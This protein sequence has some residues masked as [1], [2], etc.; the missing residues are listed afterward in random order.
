MNLFDGL[1]ASL[2]KNAEVHLAWLIAALMIAV[3]VTGCAKPADA[4]PA[5]P[6][7]YAHGTKVIKVQ[8]INDDWVLCV[9]T[10]GG[11][12]YGQAITCDFNRARANP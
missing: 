12:G 7:V 5:T 8:N 1:P 2:K 11:Y 6:G 10:S 4:A 3:V 9:I